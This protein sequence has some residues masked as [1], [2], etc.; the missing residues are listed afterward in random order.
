M[1]TTPI[2]RG[3]KWLE[4]LLARH[5]PGRGHHTT[6]AAAPRT[7]GQQHHL[8][9]AATAPK[10]RGVDCVQR[11]QQQAC[12]WPRMRPIDAAQSQLQSELTAVALASD[13]SARVCDS[14]GVEQAYM[15]PPCSQH[16]ASM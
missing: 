2:W 10:A 3:D 4:W 6:H 13:K 16:V 1:E 5:W 9:Q 14:L 15:K 8:Q 12:K 11:W 7:C